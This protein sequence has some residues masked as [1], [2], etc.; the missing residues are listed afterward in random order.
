M[1][2]FSSVGRFLAMV[3]L[4]QNRGIEFITSRRS[5]R[6]TF[7]R[8]AAHWISNVWPPSPGCDIRPAVPKT[9]LINGLR[10]RL[11]S[12]LHVLVVCF[13][14]IVLNLVDESNFKFFST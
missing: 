12:P 4:I 5:L 14:R 11:T 2:Y 7:Q 9:D 1:L 6:L 8:I 13:G 10:S 3:D